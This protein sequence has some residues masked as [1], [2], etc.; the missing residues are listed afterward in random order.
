MDE[1]NQLPVS[2]SV[3]RRLSVPIASLTNAAVLFCLGGGV[4]VG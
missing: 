3:R 4:G 2:A 1:E